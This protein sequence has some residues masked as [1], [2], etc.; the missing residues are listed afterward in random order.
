MKG[1]ETSPFF[2]P[3]PCGNQSLKILAAATTLESACCGKELVECLIACFSQQQCGHSASGLNTEWSVLD[4]VV[5]IQKN[6]FVQR[7]LQ[8]CNDVEANPGP[9]NGKVLI[10]RHKFL[11]H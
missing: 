1:E 6:P 5:G 7:F 3:Q 8:C 9:L 11:F 2:Q 10:P 4:P